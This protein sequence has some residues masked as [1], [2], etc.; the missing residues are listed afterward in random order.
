[1]ADRVVRGTGR[2][3]SE[4]RAVGRDRGAQDHGEG[5]CIRVPTRDMPGE[6]SSIRRGGTVVSV[7]AAVLGLALAIALAGIAAAAPAA[8]RVAERSD[9][10]GTAPASTLRQGNHSSR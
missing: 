2:R 7:S 1:M 5:G 8:E 6:G 4:R 10:R 9:A 3:A